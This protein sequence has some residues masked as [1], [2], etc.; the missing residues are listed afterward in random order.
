MLP[1]FPNLNA[2]WSYTAVRTLYER[3]LRAAVICP[4]SRSSPLTFAFAQLDGIEAIP[5]L[6]ERSAAFFALGLARQRGTPVALVCTSGTAAANFIPAIIE[7]SESGTPLIVL[8]ADRPPELRQCAAGQTI[9]Q[10][11]LYG[12]YVRYYQEV[13]LP[14]NDVILLRSLRQLVSHSY[15][16][17]SL[18]NPGPIHLN[19]PFRDPLPPVAVGG[20]SSVLSECGDV[21]F[22]AFRARVHSASSEQLTLPDAFQVEEG[23]I[24]VGPQNIADNELEAWLNNLQ[25]FSRQLGWPL[26]ADALNS[27]RSH[28]DPFESLI[29][30]YDLILRR[31]SRPPSPRAVIVI[32][33]LPTSKLLRQWLSESEPHMLYLGN[34]SRNG[35]PTFSRSQVI[36]CDFRRSYPTVPQI[37]KGAYLDQWLEADHA[38]AKSIDQ[39]MAAVTE[40]FE[41]KVAYQLAKTIT[42]EGA[43]CVSNSMPPRDLEYFARS[44]MNGYNVF[45]SRGANGIDGILSTAMGVAHFRRKTF[46]L[47][48]DLALLHDSNGGLVAKELRGDLTIVLINNNGGGIFEML[49]V[50]E[51]EPVFERYFGTPQDVNY[52]SWA[53]VYGIDYLCPKNWDDFHDVLSQEPSGVRLIEVKVDRKRNA[54]LRRELM[55][56]LG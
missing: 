14:E 3:G 32:G 25:G 8:T 51:F 4:G 16:V 18:V 21:F 48:G 11:K 43:L 38:I 45:S 24:L 33:E 28:A 19:F 46:L 55:K 20:F 53:A 40:L 15:D 49:P 29:C 12:N 54:V 7:A 35:D 22:D 2:Q 13:A 39:E 31:K 34:A 27:V 44:G 47:T 10:V 36:S 17:S 1:E 5:V 41:C 26:C 52:E 30:H 9:D 6:D 23:L 56:R 50:A 42:K 37:E